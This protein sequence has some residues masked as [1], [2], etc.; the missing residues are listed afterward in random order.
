MIPTGFGIDFDSTTVR[1][2]LAPDIL[3]TEVCFSITI[4]DVQEDTEMFSLSIRLDFF[5]PENIIL[6]PNSLVGG[7]IIGEQIGRQTFIP[8]IYMQFHI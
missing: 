5:T 3:R 8:V 6:G 1:V 7:F 2:T 4:D